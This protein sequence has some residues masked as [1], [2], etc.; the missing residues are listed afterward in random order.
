[1]RALP[2][3]LAASLLAV[4]AAHASVDETGSRILVPLVW[5]EPLVATN[6]HVANHLPFPLKVQVR[7]VGERSS[8]APGYRVCGTLTL[9]AS[10]LTPLDYVP[11]CGLPAD[12][13]Q[14]AVVL[15]Y[16]GTGVGR[17]SARARIDTISGMTNQ[18]LGTFAVNGI[19]LGA[20]DTTQNVHVVQGLRPAS[21]QSTA[22]TTDCFFGS[23]F[24]GS[25]KGG[26]VGE[27]ALVD[28]EGHQLGT[29]FVNLRP[30]D[31][32]AVRD[33]FALFGVPAGVG[34]GVKAEVRWS[35]FGDAVYGYCLAGH[36]GKLKYE[37]TIGF[38]LMQ[39]ADP[40]DHLRRRETAAVDTP[41][42]GRFQ[43]WGSPSM[44]IR[45]GVYLRHPDIVSCGVT[46][47]DPAAQLVVTAVAPDRTMVGGLLPRTPD[48]ATVPHGSVSVSGHELWGFEVRWRPGAPI[49]PDPV[50]YTVD[51][52]SGNG[53]SLA[54]FLF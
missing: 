38:E 30:F 33:V 1:M 26:M 23:V 52:G 28:S 3:A 32:V 49:P 54:D 40:N 18:I 8:T 14:G 21:P 9:P 13:G 37:R 50:E 46:T 5:T 2:L 27:L 35:G 15:V 11:F 51:C 53:T 6:L 48:F 7:Y 4:G 45:H 17:I 41:F 10:Q 19:P 43:T 47:A 42:L 22:V 36:A 44:V 31:L 39:V 29:R 25:G 16:E 24:D 12:P 20:L 34:P